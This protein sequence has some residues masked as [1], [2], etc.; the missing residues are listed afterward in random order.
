M[1]LG[2][3]ARHTR[4][5]DAASRFVL[6]LSNKFPTKSN[7]TV[8]LV[9]N[10]LDPTFDVHAVLA[11]H[12]PANLHWLLDLQHRG[13]DS[14]VGVGLV[15]GHHSP[16]GYHVTPGGDGRPYIVP[17]NGIDDLEAFLGIGYELPEVTFSLFFVST[18]CH[19][20]SHTAFVWILSYTPK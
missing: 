4:G 13:S 8:T 5:S 19:I 9:L 16:P 12:E 10:H 20:L 1:F 14:N 11:E 2:L 7:F 3:V 18:V 17:L 15:H 6:G